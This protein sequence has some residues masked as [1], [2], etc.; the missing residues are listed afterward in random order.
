MAASLDRSDDPQKLSQDTNT[1]TA[2]GRG[3]RDLSSVSRFNKRAQ[4][5]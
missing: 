2:G 3:C 1:P 5:I 4:L